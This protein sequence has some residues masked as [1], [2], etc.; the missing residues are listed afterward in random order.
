MVLIELT[1]PFD[2]ALEGA[3]ERK[4]AKYEHLQV[5][6]RS[7]GYHTSLITLEIGSRRVPNLPGFEALQDTL[8]LPSSALRNL[9]MYAIKA[10][11]EG[12]FSMGATEQVELTSTLFFPIVVSFFQFLCNI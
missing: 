8:H 2:T 11:I 10:T 12:S 1:I 7:K 6:A 4:E 3:K 5:S 9:L